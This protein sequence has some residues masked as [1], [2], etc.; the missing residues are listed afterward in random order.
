VAAEVATARPLSKPA[1]GKQDQ[2]AAII[3]AA[4]QGLTIQEIARQHKVSVDQVKLIL[5]VAGDK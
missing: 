1:G 3:G 2:Q 4:R 5:R